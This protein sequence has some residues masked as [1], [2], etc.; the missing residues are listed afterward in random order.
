[1]SKVGIGG[2]GFLLAPI[3]PC[4]ISHQATGSL[5][6]AG[7]VPVD[8]R[9]AIWLARAAVMPGRNPATGEPRPL[10]AGELP[11]WVFGDGGPEISVLPRSGANALSDAF[12]QID[13][14]L[15]ASPWQLLAPGCFLGFPPGFTL[16]TSLDDRDPFPE[17]A[18]HAD[19]EAVSDAIIA[20]EARPVPAGSVQMRGNFA[21]EELVTESAAGEVRTWEYGYDHEGTQWRKRHYALPITPDHTLMMSAQAPVA[22]YE[23]MVFGADVVVAGFAPL[24]RT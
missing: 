2:H 24:R 8:E 23:A 18:L 11:T 3:C 5:L 22:H 20:F 10:A 21:V 19:T 13:T 4:R 15:G 9:R 1:M 12:L 7:L 14:G 17:L 6:I 16:T